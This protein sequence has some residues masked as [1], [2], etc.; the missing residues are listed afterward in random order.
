MVAELNHTGQ[1]AGLLAGV[2]NRELIRAAALHAGPYP[3]EDLLRRA[4][5]ALAG[6]EQP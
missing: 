5:A 1:F 3:A 2:L 6:E 4:E